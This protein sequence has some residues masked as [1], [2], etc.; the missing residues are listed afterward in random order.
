[1][2]QSGFKLDSLNGLNRLSDEWR[3][4]RGRSDVISVRRLREPGKLAFEGRTDL[5]DVEWGTFKVVKAVRTGLVVAP[6]FFEVLKVGPGLLEDA[7]V[8]PGVLDDVGVAPGVLEDVE[9]AQ[10]VVDGCLEEQGCSP[11]ERNLLDFKV[12][13]SFH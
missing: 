5:S 10:V 9:V 7:A 1:M 6:G 13:N 8:A 4:S 2:S 12:L 3:R 11:E